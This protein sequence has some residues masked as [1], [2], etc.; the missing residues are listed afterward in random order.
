MAKSFLYFV[1]G[2]LVALLVVAFYSY[3]REQEARKTIVANVENAVAAVGNRTNGQ[4][5]WSVINS[6][7]SQRFNTQ[8][9]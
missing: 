4:N 8:T 5:V 3:K 6:L 1:L 9:S 7:A 2:V